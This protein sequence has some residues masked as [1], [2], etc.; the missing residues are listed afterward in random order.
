MDL[1]ADVS[2]VDTKKYATQRLRA[3]CGV[4][5]TCYN[6]GT[7]VSLQKYIDLS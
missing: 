3:D 1:G 6:G 5:V 4:T 7:T 2:N